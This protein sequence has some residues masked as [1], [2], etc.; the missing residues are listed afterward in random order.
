L[1]ED[2]EEQIYPSE[3]QVAASWQAGG[4]LCARVLCRWHVLRSCYHQLL[5]LWYR[6][7]RHYVLK[8]L[9]CCCGVLSVAIV[10]GQLTMLVDGPPSL[11]SFMLWREHDF[12]TTHFLCIVP[13]IY[14][15]CVTYWS[16]F[17]LKMAG[18]HGLYSNRNTDPGSLLWCSL[19]LS[20][21]TAP[22][23][24]HYLL[25]IRVDGT[26]FQDVMGQMN[27][28]PVLGQLFNKGLPIFVG[29]LCL[30]NL[31]NTYAKFIQILGWDTFHFEW[32]PQTSADGLDLLA[33]GRR[34]IERERRHRCEERSLLELHDRSD[35]GH[36]IPLR[37]QIAQ[38][39]EDGALP[40]DWNAY[41]S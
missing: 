41:C 17:G 33:E 11:L 14:M 16:V 22:L 7:L 2:L 38:L 19:I 40:H 3:V 28:V 39:V 31:T 18:W 20:R 12:W 23:C 1:L 26:K 34:L 15:I 21:L 29:V 27:V 30:C 8:S 9:A 24:Y 25:L 4:W 35:V 5:L 36:A 6:T 13:L 37:L 10:L 32:T